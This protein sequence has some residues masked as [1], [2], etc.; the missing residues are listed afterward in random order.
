M[1]FLDFLKRNK[2]THLIS[3]P[4]PAVRSRVDQIEQSFRTSSFK[5]SNP[6]L[7]LRRRLILAR[8]LARQLVNTNTYAA[9]WREMVATY[10]VGDQGFQLQPQITKPDGSL[11]TDINDKIKKAWNDWADH[12]CSLD[13][14]DTIV[15]ICQTAI[16]N[17]A[18]DGECLY[19]IVKGNVNPYG[20]ALQA[21]DPALLDVDFSKQLSDTRSIVMGIEFEGHKPVA[22]HI[23][24]RHVGLQGFPRELERVPADEIIHIYD[25]DNFTVRGLSWL[26]P[27]FRYLTQ[28]DDFL[29]AHLKASNLAANAPLIES[30]DSSSPAPIVSVEGNGEPEPL[31]VPGFTSIYVPQG[32][33]VTATNLQFPNAQIETTVRLYL[34]AAAAALNMSYE[35]LTSDYSNT[36]FSS[37]RLGGLKE[38]SH[39][40]TCQ[41]FFVMHFLMRVY[42]VWIKQAM[43]TRRITLPGVSSEYYSVQFQPRGFSYI[44]P[45]KEM[46]AYAEGISQGL[47][48]RTQICAE[49]GSNYADNIRTLAE[50]Q[51]LAQEFGVQLD[52]LPEPTVSDQIQSLTDVIT[53]N[54]SNQ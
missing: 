46:K 32:K 40:R 19:R 41:R 11:D 34:Q 28:L 31:D 35:N 44:D 3:L 6:N 37:G 26:A 30:F 39:W 33:T 20:I 18:T 24:N 14:Q 16:R 50:E 49:L 5:F 2:S 43:L 17:T 21:I 54:Q 8:D 9:A 4:K 12:Y 45:V 13:G 15:E 25:N 48:T 7:D 29:V 36:S 23:W 51:N 1:G 22:Y 47:M 10:V 53:N 52:N 38:K 27:A 42:R